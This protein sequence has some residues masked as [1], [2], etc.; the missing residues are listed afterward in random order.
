MLTTASGCHKLII[1]YCNQS[2]F[3]IRRRGH[4]LTVVGLHR[5]C[6]LPSLKDSA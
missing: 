4:E 1:T 6:T 2:K 3:C 5:M